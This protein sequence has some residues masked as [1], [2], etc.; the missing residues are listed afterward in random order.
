MAVAVAVAAR[1]G[2]LKGAATEP[3]LRPRRAMPTRLAGLR[4]ATALGLDLGL[5]RRVVGGG[6]AEDGCAPLVSVAEEEED[7][8]GVGGVMGRADVG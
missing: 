7:G 5:T 8:G 3:R 6:G 1:A 2:G 4:L